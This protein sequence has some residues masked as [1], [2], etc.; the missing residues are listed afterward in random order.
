MVLDSMEQKKEVKKFFRTL[1]IISLLSALTLIS[2]EARTQPAPRR[3]Q[4]LKSPEVLSGRQVAFRLFAPQAD[5]VVLAG[6]WPGGQVQ[7]SRDSSGVWNV[8]AG[9][10]DPGVWEYSFRVDGLSM[11]DPLNPMIKPMHEPRTS[12]LHLPGDPPLL[13]DFQ[14]VPHGVLHTHDYHSQSLG[15][16]REIVVYTPP[17][18]EQDRKAKYPVFFLQHGMGDN[19]ATWTVHGKAHWILDNLIAQGKALPM[20]IVMMNGHAAV[21]GDATKTRQ[22]NTT[23]FERDLIEEV[24][25]FIDTHYRVKTGP[26]H[27]ALCGLSMGGGQSLIIGLNH[28]ERFAWIGGFSASVPAREAIAAV[29]ADPETTNKKIRLLW[30]ACGKD[31]FLLKRN[32]DFIALLRENKIR[33]EW[34]LTGGDHSWPIWRGYLGKLAQRLFRRNS[35]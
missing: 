1:P 10:I 19:Q 20:L 7:M 5:T 34:L 8:T 14:D 24:M 2:P 31:D 17:G 22:E 15:R 28:L 25:P 9:P 18:Y 21:W 6:Q 23:L 16:M 35:D 13:F 4:A 3:P 27:R 33:H 26:E 30:I 11:I 32:E 29:L 12:I